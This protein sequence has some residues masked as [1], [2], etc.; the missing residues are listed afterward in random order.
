ML[1]WLQELLTLDKPTALAVASIAVSLRITQ[2]AN[3]T[4]GVH[5]VLANE[6]ITQG[7]P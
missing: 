1:I 5:A 2:V 6:T 7:L 4:W 3:E